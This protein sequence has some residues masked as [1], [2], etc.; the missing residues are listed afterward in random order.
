MASSRP[1]LEVDEYKLTPN[2]LA[3]YQG[4]S[5]RNLFYSY[6]GKL[7]DEQDN[8][9]FYLTKRNPVN[10]EG[11]AFHK[12]FGLDGDTDTG[13][14]LYPVLVESDGNESWEYPV[15]EV[16]IAHYEKVFLDSLLDDTGEPFQGPN[17][18]VYTPKVKMA[19]LGKE[20]GEDTILGLIDVNFIHGIGQAGDAP[21]QVDM[22][23]ILYDYINKRGLKAGLAHIRNR[24]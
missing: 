23:C 15:K 16:P 3:L 11:G 24:I 8:P 20:G 5:S 2:F 19:V 18:C 22:A 10:I 21:T 1:E 4:A 14:K 7:K 12:K 9:L 6:S 17:F 13:K